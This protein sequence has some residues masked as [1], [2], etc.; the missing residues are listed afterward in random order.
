LVSVI[1]GAIDKSRLP[2]NCHPL[3]GGAIRRHLRRTSVTHQ[4]YRSVFYC[5]TARKTI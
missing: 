4:T 3:Q 2:D 5:C 1:I